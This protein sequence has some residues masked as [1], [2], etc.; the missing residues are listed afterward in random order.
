MHIPD[1]VLND[2]ARMLAGC[3]PVEWQGLASGYRASVI[4]QIES[5][6][7]PI[8]DW[9]REEALRAVRRKL[10]G[11]I[12]HAEDNGHTVSGQGFFEPA[13]GVSAVNVLAALEGAERA[14]G[15]ID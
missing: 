5:A 7:Q 2:A 11:E 8:A 3:D 10:E 4:T 12:H 6:A 15:V 14:L 13:P 9:A 1:E